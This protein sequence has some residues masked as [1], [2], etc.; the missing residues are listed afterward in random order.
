MLTL[1]G[2]ASNDLIAFN[3]V[4]LRTLER[5]RALEGSSTRALE[6][7]RADS[8]SAPALECRSARA[9][10]QS[11]SRGVLEVSLD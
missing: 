1:I 8:L 10:G 11:G 5:L 2:L 4:A 6:R 7:L 3:D 9:R